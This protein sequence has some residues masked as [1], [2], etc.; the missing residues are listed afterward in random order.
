MVCRWALVRLSVDCEEYS[1]ANEI[2][3]FWSLSLIYFYFYVNKSNLLHFWYIVPIVA[4]VEGLGSVNT[5]PRCYRLHLYGFYS[6]LRAR[7]IH[8]S[9]IRMTRM[10]NACVF[11][12]RIPI[13]ECRERHSI[14]SAPRGRMNRMFRMK[15]QDGARRDECCGFN[16]VS[17][18]EKIK[19]HFY[20]MKHC[21]QF[22]CTKS[23]RF[24]SVTTL[25][26]WPVI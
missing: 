17:T 14:H 10:S 15:I 12:F 8:N 16:Y 22:H 26:A 6:I 19:L 5:L 23:T 7:F 25:S 4:R 11:L 24:F 1:E 2:L 3:A 13:P 9:G 21:L 20:T 18:G